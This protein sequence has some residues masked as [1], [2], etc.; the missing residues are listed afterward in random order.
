MKKVMSKIMAIIMLF[1]V[2]I[3]TMGSVAPV[4]AAA[5]SITIKI[6]GKKVAFKYQ[7][8]KITYG[9]IAQAGVIV[10]KLGGKCVYSKSKKTITITKGKVK[11]TFNVN[12]TRVL[13]GTKK[14]YSK[15]KAVLKSNVPFVDV[16][17]LSTKLG[18]KYLAYSSTDKCLR[19]NKV[20]PKPA[21]PTPTKTP[22]PIATPTLTPTATAKP[23]PIPTPTL[24]PTPAPTKTPTP[25]ATPTKT[26]T[27]S[28]TPSAT[29]KPS[30]TPAPSATP[31]PTATPTPSTTGGP[32]LQSVLKM[33][34]TQNN[35][36]EG[37]MKPPM[38]APRLMS[39]KITDQ[40]GNVSYMGDTTGTICGRGNSTWYNAQPSDWS[41]GPIK[42]APFK[43][44]F[45]SKV[46]ML[47]MGADKTWVLLA[48]RTDKTMIRNAI[49]LDIASKLSFQFTSRYRWVELYLNGDY[50]GL[51][52]L[53]DQ[54]EESDT[55]VSIQ[56]LVVND[57]QPSFLLEWDDKVRNDDWM[58]N[59]SNWPSTIDPGGQPV[60]N[61]DYF[62][63]TVSNNT[64]HSFVFKYPKEKDLA[65]V[66][67]DAARTYIKNYIASA[68]T[69]MKNAA[70]SSDYLNYIDVNSFYDFYIVNEFTNNFDCSS[71]SSIYMYKPKDGKLTMGPVWDF[72]L[73]MGSASGSINAQ[74]WL[75]TGS[76]WFAS[77][78]KNATFKQG[79]K[80][81]WNAVKSIVKAQ[82]FDDVDNLASVV[83]AAAQRNHDKWKELSINTYDTST[84]VPLPGTYSGEISRL[85]TWLSTK[86]TWLD[87]QINKW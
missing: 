55:R 28:P 17:Y 27:P 39:C 48:N 71:H 81:R 25:T 72:D 22:N 26:P 16:V 79:L 9:Y 59:L 87:T 8:Q 5:Y 68:N 11:L 6:D 32:G 45:P 31:T 21:T 47:G 64:Q 76:P 56:N 4:S 49:A 63:F 53:A 2:S 57:P 61:K 23:T 58:Y 70:T 74:Q 86:Y 75:M 3:G 44:E 14:E 73:S 35:P 42:K 19:I 43:I 54:V 30:V 84:S 52:Q 12:S 67:G 33:Y 1:S 41:K 51:Y 78:L 34:I 65:T 37:I 80:A 13:N 36:S 20:K 38:A 29:P 7:P 66:P 77:L 82:G 50:K 85:K 40:T 24:T 10:P 15:V 18:Y 69:A 60:A 46:E 83:G 62:Y